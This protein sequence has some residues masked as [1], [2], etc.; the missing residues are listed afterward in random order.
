MVVPCVA[1]TL[2]AVA[3]FWLFVSR[4]NSL[5]GQTDSSVQTLLT[6]LLMFDLSHNLLGDGA[7]QVQSH[8]QLISSSSL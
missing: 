3:Y 5:R 1:M 8:Q 6:G 2:L 4:W 7:A